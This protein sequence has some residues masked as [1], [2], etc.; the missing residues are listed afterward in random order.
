MKNSFICRSLLNYI[1]K[2]YEKAVTGSAVQFKIPAKAYNLTTIYLLLSSICANKSLNQDNEAS[3]HIS[4]QA[5]EYWKE[6]SDEDK[7]LI[8]DIC[9]KYPSWIDDKGNLTA[10]RNQT[11]EEN[12]N[13]RTLL[14][15]VGDDL[16][17][18]K[19]S[20]A[21]FLDCGPSSMFNVVLKGSF[22]P[23][24][25]SIIDDNG[26]L[27]SDN[28]EEQ[29][30]DKL[31][32]YV[33]RNSDLSRIDQFLCNLDFSS[34]ESY[35]LSEIIGWQLYKLGIPS[36]NLK[37]TVNRKNFNPTISKAKNLIDGNAPLDSAKPLIKKVAAVRDRYLKNPDDDKIAYLSR[38]EGYYPYDNALDYLAACEDII[39]NTTDSLHENELF[40]KTDSGV[41]VNY[42][43]KYK[44]EVHPDPSEKT[45]DGLP[46]PAILNAVW[47][48]LNQYIHS[49]MVDDEDNTR[50][51]RIIIEPSKFTHNIPKAVDSNDQ[52]LTVYTDYLIPY[53]GQ[54]DDLLCGILEG[55]GDDPDSILDG[56]EIISKLCRDFDTYDGKMMEYKPT[57]IPAMAFNVTIEGVNK[58]S[59]IYSYKLLIPKG[60]PISYS[61]IFVDQQKKISDEYNNDIFIPAFTLG[62]FPEFFDKSDSDSDEFFEDLV[63]NSLETV[64]AE[65]LYSESLKGPDTGIWAA[66]NTLSNYYKLYIE[67]IVNRGLYSVVNGSHST[68]FYKSY[69]ELLERLYK[70]ENKN[71][72]STLVTRMLK[73]FWVIDKMQSS[74]ESLSDGTF[75]A[76]CLTIL[77]PAMV[78]MISSE[79]VY[80]K[81]AFEN[82]LNYCFIHRLSS[83]QMNNE[84]NRLIDFATVQAPIPCLL[85]KKGDVRTQVKGSDWLFKIGNINS[86]LYKDLLLS[87]TFASDGL[88]DIDDI[89]DSE[90]TRTTDESNLLFQLMRDYFRSYAG[91]YDSLK[92]AVFMPVNIQAVMASIIELIKK[93]IYADNI[94]DGAFPAY[95]Y[96][97]D[98]E[99]YADPEDEGRIGIWI[100]KFND[101]FAQKALA[102][103]KFSHIDYSIGY[104]MIQTY[105]DQ[106]SDITDS[107]S[108]DFQADIVLLYE[109]PNASIWKNNDDLVTDLEN[110]KDMDI[111]ATKIKIKFPMIEKL[112]PKEAIDNKK[113]G[114]KK[115]FKL[116]S[117]RQFSTYT[118]YINLMYCKKRSSLSDKESVVI[119][120]KYDFHKWLSLLDWC[121]NRSERVIAL[122]SE[123][124]KDLI[125]YSDSSDPSSLNAKSL[126]GFGSGVGANA[127]LNYIVTSKLF[128]RKQMQEKLAGRLSAMFSNVPY[129]DIFQIA[130]QLYR[131]SEDMA[132]LSLIRTLSSYEFY[133]HDF[134]GYSMIRHMLVP[135]G[136]PFCNV[137]LSLD[138]YKHWFDDS[139]NFRADLLWVCAYLIPVDNHFEC[140]LK[141]TVIESKMAYNVFEN[142]VEKAFYQ[143]RDTRKIL[144][145]HFRPYEAAYD[146]RYWWMQLHRIIASNSTIMNDMKRPEVMQALEYLAEGVFKVEWDSYIF[147]FEQSAGFAGEETE[148]IKC[149]NDYESV[150]A[151]VMT[152]KG[153][154]QYMKSVV[155][156]SFKQ[157]V[158][159]LKHGADYTCMLSDA[160]LKKAIKQDDQIRL[161]NLAGREKASD[162]NIVSSDEEM[163]EEIEDE[164]IEDLSDAPIISFT[165]HIHSANTPEENSPE[166][167]AMVAQSSEATIPESYKVGDE[168]DG[169]SNQPDEVN[170]T[171]A[172]FVETSDYDPAFDVNIPIGKTANG[173]EVFWAY[174][175]NPEGG[176]TNRHMFI[177][178]SSGSGKSYAIKAILGELARRHQASLIVDYTDGFTEDKFNDF[179]EFVSPQYVVKKGIKLPINPFLMHAESYDNEYDVATR[180]SSVFHRIYKDI[181]DNQLS[182]FNDVIEFGVEKYGTKYTMSQL[183]IDLETAARNAKGSD[184]NT[185]LTL[186]Q[187]IKPFC[188]VDPFRV[189][190]NEESAWKQ[191]F[192]DLKRKDLITIF[193]LMNISNDIQHAI[194][195]FILWDL[196]YYMTAVRSVETTPHTIVLD[197]VQN[198]DVNDADTPVYKLLKEGRKFGLGVIAA[199]QDIAG[200]KGVS[201]AGTAA[202]MGSGTIMFFSPPPNEMDAYA[203]L[204]AD[205][206]RHRNKDGWKLQLSSLKRGECIFFSNDNYNKRCARKIKITSLE[207]RGLV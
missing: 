36:I 6:S 116:I 58:T 99:F 67:E 21:H 168:P 140:E 94:K 198:L 134:F 170:I 174:G 169:S 123:I 9:S 195:D 86:D 137:V 105:H 180:V 42:I 100:A 81:D 83:A 176:L 161:D 163:T 141:L 103:P 167:S 115:R 133:S 162:E 122:G 129:N 18:D 157:F 29:F 149:S 46:L 171:E 89:P 10:Y 144:E 173:E 107:I 200:L 85:D 138:S 66:I 205:I 51:A 92:I 130:V 37:D 126:V 74:A 35:F 31:L 104:R 156:S 111:E 119:M 194:T 52:N 32:K 57:K 73:A 4:K 139:I 12:G 62:K 38:P 43:L 135:E 93:T 28:E 59:V 76:G 47:L 61:R 63:G 183:Q 15:L 175:N 197:E 1:I 84:W 165:D 77:H 14:V 23:W 181:G 147:A 189:S 40:L 48:S 118:A 125:M 79:Y 44:E 190:D 25:K 60:S 16:I 65:N 178:G 82:R 121:S 154:Q 30:C 64:G 97:L 88:K 72:Y 179:P 70:Y 90:L 71:H 166:E 202:L 128:D 120:E 45:L 136:E 142:Y 98:I 49:N 184:R 131:D 2:T 53:F 69:N 68:D 187:K 204:L 102:D 150:N 114:Q 22:R 19:A 146:S 96:K 192:Y 26:D 160:E 196:Y 191:V 108:K 39:N 8:D 5:V 91:A 75:P 182:V 145:K 177:L 148:L 20:L 50:V 207:D 159:S 155:S 13:G 188:K 164:A 41:L 56:V 203:K 201:S 33:Y 112:F 143:V 127:N 54:V 113:H 199:T 106:I 55:S 3:V 34:Y 27:L 153:I 193:Q 132:D 109:S 152:S 158:L 172:P 185:K 101:F 206:D 7:Q 186:A 117:N 24:I 110:V 87:V 124:D 95:P 11:G 80:L 151:I 78:E 17:D